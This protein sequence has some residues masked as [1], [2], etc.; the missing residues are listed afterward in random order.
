MLSD[1]P[2][3]AFSRLGTDADLESYVREHCWSKAEQRGGW[4]NPKLYALVRR[5]PLA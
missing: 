1:R 2:A 5:N 3:R 4:D